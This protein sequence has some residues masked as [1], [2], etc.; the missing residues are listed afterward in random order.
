MNISQI[1]KNIAGK[2]RGVIATR[3]LGMGEVVLARER[4]FAAALSG[5]ESAYKVQYR[6]DL[7]NIYMTRF[8][9]SFCR[10]IAI[11]ALSPLPLVA[12]RRNATR[13]V[14]AIVKTASMYFCWH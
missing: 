11:I 1:E 3:E 12:Q 10:H 7:P 2:G 13:A 5:D 14:I 4:P 8:L 9:V 6:F